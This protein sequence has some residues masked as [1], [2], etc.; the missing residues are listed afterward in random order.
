MSTKK[1]E[2]EKLCTGRIFHAGISKHST[3]AFD[4]LVDKAGE[5]VRQ[6]GPGTGETDFKAKHEFTLMEILDFIFEK[7]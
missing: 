2:V 6:A 4:W 5:L 3:R 1:K 7:S